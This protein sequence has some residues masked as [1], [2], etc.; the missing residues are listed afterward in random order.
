VIG[1]A[2]V[3][4]SRLRMRWMRSPFLLGYIVTRDEYHQSSGLS[5]FD[6]I[7]CFITSSDIPHLRAPATTISIVLALVEPD[8]TAIN[9]LTAVVMVTSR[10][11]RVCK[12]L[13]IMTGVSKTA[14]TSAVVSIQTIRVVDAFDRT[15][16]FG[17]LESLK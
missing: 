7:S 12:E 1:D 15:C 5:V 11:L 2:L 6:V 8:N 14:T 17:S 4:I 16:T 13:H 10:V 3:H 9:I